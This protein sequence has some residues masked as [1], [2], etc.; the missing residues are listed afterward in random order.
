MKRNITP[1]LIALSA[2]AVIAFFYPPELNAQ[3]AVTADTLYTMEGP[4]VTNGVVLIRDGRIEQAGRRDDLAIPQGY[5]QYNAQ[6]VTPGLIDART[7]VGLA[8]YY[9]QDHDQDQLE[10]SH[11]LQPDLRAFDAYNAREELVG[12]L[13]Q[14]GITTMHTG[15]APGAVISGQTMIVK[16][17]GHTIDQAI[18]DST[19]ALAITLGSTVGNN[20]DTPGTRAKGVAMLRQE[21]IRA[22][23]YSEKRE[24][25]DAGGRPGTDLKLEA[26]AGMLEGKT[27][28]LITAQRSQDI[29]TALRLRDEFGFPLILDGAAESFMLIEELT[30]AD[31]PVLIHPTMARTRGDMENAAFDTASKL[32]E[33]GILFA[34]QS[35]YESYVPKTRVVLFEAAIAVANG[36][37]RIQA[38]EGLTVNPA[39]ILNISDRVGSIAPG[40]DADLVL[41]NG[42]PFEY[43]SR[44]THVII[45]GEVVY[46]FE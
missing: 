1:V 28:A 41:F 11:A 40:K 12:F 31:V 23:E 35:G 30:T 26:L 17:V 33:A 3:I 5:K 21:L 9:N 36:L 29:M 8:G 24:N 25:E 43:T 13:R 7:V 6:V 45:N 20:F 42:D 37:N 10:Y 16:T 18:I 38:L 15:H 27:R 19:T 46:E 22:R 2:A 32:A 34:F 39:A 14:N 4:P 44:P